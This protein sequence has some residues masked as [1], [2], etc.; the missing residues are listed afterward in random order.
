MSDE[1]TTEEVRKAWIDLLNEYTLTSEEAE[2]EK[3][4]R[5]LSAHNAEVAK[6]EK[7]RIMKFLMPILEKATIMPL[8]INDARGLFMDIDGRE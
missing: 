1:L 6:A 5:W 8:S 4:D 2:E 7:E 3:F